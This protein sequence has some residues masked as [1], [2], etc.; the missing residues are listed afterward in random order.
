MSSKIVEAL[1]SEFPELGK[2]ST[3]EITLALDEVFPNL[4]ENDQEFARDLELYNR[5]AIGGFAEDFGK[6][7]VASIYDTST[8]AYG[9]LETIA[10]PFSEEWTK[11]FREL[12]D[13]AAEMGQD[14]RETGKLASGLSDASFD[15]GCL[16]Y[17]S[18]SPRD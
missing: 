7:F 11:Y 10:K 5:G 6:S 17:T 4:A 14:L 2:N 8:S 1:R 3:E 13:Q 12:S 15:R 16:L 18:P 9:V